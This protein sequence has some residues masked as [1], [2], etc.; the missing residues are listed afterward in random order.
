MLFQEWNASL[1][2]SRDHILYLALPQWDAI[3]QIDSLQ[4][5]FAIHESEN[6]LQFP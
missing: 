3:L 4:S 1:A 2:A 6:E 5:M